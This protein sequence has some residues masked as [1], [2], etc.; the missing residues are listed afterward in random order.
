MNT[1]FN[2]NWESL[3]VGDEVCIRRASHTN[4]EIDGLKFSNTWLADMNY[5]VGQSGIIKQV[6]GLDF[7]IK[8]TSTPRNPGDWKW[9]P[10]WILEKV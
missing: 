10:G 7:Q 3:K 2:P 8:I 1:Y 9:Y 4:E 5:A 6:D